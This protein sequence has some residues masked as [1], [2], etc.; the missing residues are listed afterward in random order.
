[1]KSIFTNVDSMLFS[2]LYWTEIK[3]FEITFLKTS[4]HHIDVI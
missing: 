4:R 1:M 2:I 3:V